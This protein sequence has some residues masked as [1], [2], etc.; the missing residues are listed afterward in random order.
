MRKDQLRVGEDIPLP[1]S[2]AAG[3]EKT[4]MGTD[5]R[6]LVNF[7]ANNCEFP[8]SEAKLSAETEKGREEK[9]KSV[10]ALK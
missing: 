5:T 6:R 1:S 8:T 3:W 7:I 9:P 10:E 4:R 2:F